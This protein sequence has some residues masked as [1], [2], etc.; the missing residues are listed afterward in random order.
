MHCG[1]KCLSSCAT[2]PPPPNQGC[3][4]VPQSE[5]RAHEE[6]LEGWSWE[7]VARTVQPDRVTNTTAV[8]CRLPPQVFARYLRTCF[9]PLLQAPVGA[10][11]VTGKHRHKT[12]ISPGRR[13]RFF[14]RLLGFRSLA[15][16]SRRRPSH[17]SPSHSSPSHDPSL[18]THPSCLASD[19]WPSSL[20]RDTSRP[21]ST[22]ASHPRRSLVLL[23]PRTS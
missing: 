23:V 7:M 22:E 13:F 15:S 16:F 18:F 17:S 9:A 1:C 20:P 6:G 12:T 21:A 2:L 19:W 5:Y 8:L 10:H 4:H 3:N 14:A 11:A